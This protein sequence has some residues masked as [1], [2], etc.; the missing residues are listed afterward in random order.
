[1]DILR[2]FKCTTKVSKENVHKVIAEIAS[3]EVIQKPHLIASCWQNVFTSL[4]K[5]KA[6][7]DIS[8]LNNLYREL[9]PTAKK[10]ITLLK[11][12]PRD[13]LERDTF[14][15][16]KRFIRG[17][18]ESVLTKLVKFITGSDSLTV[19]TIDVTFTKYEN[20]LLGDP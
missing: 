19:P 17:L 3:Q 4:G 16:F 14:S 11:L 9:E 18:P 10:L 15:S 7:I 2:K 12:D 20:E 8:S 1:M 13:D 6:F 5:T